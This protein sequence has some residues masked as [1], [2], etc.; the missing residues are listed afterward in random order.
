MP[1]PGIDAQPHAPMADLQS[2]KGSPK[3]V[4][5]QAFPAA[6]TVVH[7]AGQDRDGPEAPDASA[8]SQDRTRSLGQGDQQRY[9]GRRH[10]RSGQPSER[11]EPPG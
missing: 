8:A 6:L 2:G 3:W 10:C 7:P 9:R 1:E 4:V 5:G 11:G